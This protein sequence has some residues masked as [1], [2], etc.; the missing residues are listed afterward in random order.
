MARRKRPTELET[1]PSVYLSDLGWIRSTEVA[2][3]LDVSLPTVTDW[4]RRGV[5]G[6]ALIEDAT[7]N[8]FYFRPA[9]Q[10]VAD[11]YDPTHWSVSAIPTLKRMADLGLSADARDK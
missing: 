7:G 3:I 9:I 4:W 2:E 6:V 1:E 8:R 5:L 11:G 10:A